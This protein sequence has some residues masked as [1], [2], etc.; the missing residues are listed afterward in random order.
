LNPNAQVAMGLEKPEAVLAGITLVK[1]VNHAVAL[2][3]ELQ[4]KP[5]QKRTP[6]TSSHFEAKTLPACGKCL[7]FKKPML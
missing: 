1:I 2:E 7:T 5:L 3:K 4:R 6:T